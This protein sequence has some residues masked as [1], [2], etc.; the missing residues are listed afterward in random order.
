MLYFS[1]DYLIN[2]PVVCLPVAANFGARQKNSLKYGVSWYDFVVLT[3]FQA[4]AIDFPQDSQIIK[5]N[6]TTY[7]LIQ[8]S[9]FQFRLRLG[10]SV[11]QEF[12]LLGKAI[13]GLE[14]YIFALT[15][16]CLAMGPFIYYVST[17]RA[18]VRKWQF[19][20]IYSNM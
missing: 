8:N 18:L 2:F 11:G 20:L 16:K 9:R 3:S 10:Y 4:G 7:I 13:R 5:V 6:S 17:W 1:L 19:L 15:L 12:L 14:F